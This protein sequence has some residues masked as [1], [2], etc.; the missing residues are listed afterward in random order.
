MPI[1]IVIEN[2]QSTDENK[3][4][5]K[6]KMDLLTKREELIN[7]Y[8]MNEVVIGKYQRLNEEIN[9]KIY[10]IDKKIKKEG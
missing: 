6:E 8:K 5:K 1:F 2:E 4:S 3:L 7:K 10:A 9:N